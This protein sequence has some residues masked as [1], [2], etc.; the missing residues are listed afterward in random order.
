M[1]KFVHTHQQ[2]RLRDEGGGG[3]AQGTMAAGAQLQLVS[4]P[5][6]HRMRSIRTQLV[7]SSEAVVLRRHAL[8]KA[9]GERAHEIRRKAVRP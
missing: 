3:G 7:L 2:C 9:L 6:Q 8:N 5:T 4:T 1:T